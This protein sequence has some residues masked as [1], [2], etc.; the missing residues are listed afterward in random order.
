MPAP[1]EVSLPEEVSLLADV[2]LPDGRSASTASEGTGV[3]VELA[4]AVGASV[5]FGVA[6]S[7]ENM[8]GPL[9]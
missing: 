5:S 2:S 4:W 3:S 6:G 9:F 8:E 1:A 7:E